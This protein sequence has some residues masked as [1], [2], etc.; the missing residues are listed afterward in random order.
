MVKGYPS[1]ITHEI[2]DHIN[3]KLVKYYNEN[4]SKNKYY[5][6]SLYDLTRS[7][8]E[9][10]LKN[11]SMPDALA[12]MFLKKKKTVTQK[13]KR[14]YEYCKNM[15]E[16]R[17]WET[18]DVDRYCFKLEVL[19]RKALSEDQW[20]TLYPG[21][22]LDDVQSEKL[23]EVKAWYKQPNSL[24]I[25]Y[26]GEE[27]KTPRKLFDNFKD[28]LTID[29]LSIMKELYDF[30]IEN[31]TFSIMDD[32]ANKPVFSSGRETITKKSN[33]KN[34]IVIFASEDGRRRSVLTFDDTAFDGNDSLTLFDLKDNSILSYLLKETMRYTGGSFPIIIEKIKLIRA[35]NNNTNRRPSSQDYDEIDRR[36]RKLSHATIDNYEDDKWV[37]AFHMVD[38]VENQEIDSRKYVAF[39]P[40]DYMITQIE[41]NRVSQLP[42]DLKNKLDSNAAKLLYAPLMLQRVKAFK[43]MMAQCS[44]NDYF[45]VIFQYEHFL[46]FVNFGKGNQGSKHAE[47]LR[48]LEEYKNKGIF[49]HDYNYIERTK[50]YRIIFNP[51]TDIEIQDLGYY[52]GE[53]FAS[54]D[55]NFKQI[56]AFAFED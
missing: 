28:D 1:Q 29:I 26:P 52:F 39:K 16:T 43:K 53:D 10:D 46:R 47:I 33:G 11:E 37:G 19:N 3:Q 42:T 17:A 4:C 56:A 2:T 23:E 49:I 18:D 22:S 45:E 12:R 9:E 27:R 54:D 34:S 30:D 6:N 5:E 31:L 14:Q 48:I 15:V 25:D 24:L 55:L 38:S 13:K 35:A 41:S 8:I 40:S 50:S 36:L 20:N 44:A 32:L 51:L 21:K 7:I